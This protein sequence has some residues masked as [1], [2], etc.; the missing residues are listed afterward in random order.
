MSS[1]PGGW[2]ENFILICIKTKPPDRAGGLR[3]RCGRG[4]QFASTW[5]KSMWP[6]GENICL[7]R[8]PWRGSCRSISASVYRVRVTPSGCLYVSGS[9]SGTEIM[10][11]ALGMSDRRSDASA[12]L[13]PRRGTCIRLVVMMNPAKRPGYIVPRVCTLPSAKS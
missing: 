9:P 7:I 4:L 12:C 5:I 3:G 6:F 13:S 10:P 1:V 2:L 8:K 11:C